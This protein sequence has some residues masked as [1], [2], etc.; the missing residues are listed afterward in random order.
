MIQTI[1]ESSTEFEG[2]ELPTCSE[3]Q[4]CST[5]VIKFNYSRLKHFGVV[6]P[7]SCMWSALNSVIHE[8]YY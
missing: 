2:T 6:V 1:T 7:K 4:Y 5:E 8:D 3:C